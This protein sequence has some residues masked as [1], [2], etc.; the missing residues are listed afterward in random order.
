M[1]NDGELAVGL[2]DLYVC[3]SGLHAEGIVVRRV[4]DHRG[5]LRPRDQKIDNKAGARCR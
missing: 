3:G 5:G 2:L 4:N 1:V